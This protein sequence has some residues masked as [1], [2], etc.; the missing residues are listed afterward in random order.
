MPRNAEKAREAHL[1]R[2]YGITIEDYNRILKEQSGKCAVC[3]KPPK[4]MRLAVDHC[5]KTGKI[6]GL[7]CSYC[8]R[9]VIGRHTLEILE[10]GVRYLRAAQ[11]KDYGIVPKRKRRPKKSTTRKETTNGEKTIV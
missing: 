9:R 7:L 3:G 4:T 6:R 1:K 2:T 5:H 10:A 11:E 8:N